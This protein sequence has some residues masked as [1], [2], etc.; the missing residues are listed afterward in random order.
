MPI[1]PPDVPWSDIGAGIAA[2]GMLAMGGLGLLNLWSKGKKS[3]RASFLT[4]E[5]E[6]RK[7]IANLAAEF[8][9]H[10]RDHQKTLEEAQDGIGEIR[11][12]IAVLMD[13]T[14]RD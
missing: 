2:L 14:R 6:L 10:S 13:R 12:H 7:S 5:S 11:T 8:R 9:A 1:S 3:E 4:E